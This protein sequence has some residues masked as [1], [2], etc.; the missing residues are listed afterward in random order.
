VSDEAG[1]PSAAAPPAKAPVKLPETTEGMPWVSN[2]EIKK[3]ANPFTDRD[4]RMFGYAWSGFLVRII[5]IFGAVF[6]VYQFLAARED[7]RVE[8]TLDLADI[9]EK[10]EYQAAQ[11]ALDVRIGALNAKFRADL[12][13]NPSEAQRALFKRRIGAIAMTDAGGEGLEAFQ[14]SFDRIVYF[15]NRVG[16]CVETDLCS[17]R[18]A[19]AYFKDFAVSFWGYFAGY[20]DEQRRAGAPT[21]AGPLEAFV[22]VAPAP[23]ATR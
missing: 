17:R 5:L 11:R 16:S 20:I 14:G 12:G 21:Y 22:G 13:S 9:W 23:T 18:I 10:E 8:R 7:K 4:W 1:P 3:E 6:T 2:H 15:L 19:D